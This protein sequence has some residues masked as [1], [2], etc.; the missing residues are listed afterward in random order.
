MRKPQETLKPA[1]AESMLGTQHHRTQA[2][3]QM[4]TWMNSWETYLKTPTASDNPS[5]NLL[6]TPSPTTEVCYIFQL[7]NITE[8]S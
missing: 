1:P 2:G 7:I 6:H 5:A 8:K 3:M 4:M